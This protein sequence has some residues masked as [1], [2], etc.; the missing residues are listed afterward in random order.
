[1]R[2]NVSYLQLIGKP[3]A[4]YET[5]NFLNQKTELLNLN[6]SGANAANTCDIGDLYTDGN[7]N[8]NTLDFY[9]TAFS[10]NNAVNKISE[11][12]CNRLYEG[13]RIFLT[14]ENSLF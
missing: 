9:V 8:D 1:M 5:S 13:Q 6:K 12:C 7:T 3:L 4:V 14:V 11:T 10:C 2:L